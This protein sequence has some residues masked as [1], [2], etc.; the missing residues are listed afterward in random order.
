[1]T[2]IFPIGRICTL[3]APVWRTRRISRSIP[4]I[5]L[6]SFV[7]QTIGCIAVSKMKVECQSIRKELFAFKGQFAHKARRTIERLADIG[8]DS[9]HLL[10]CARVECFYFQLIEPP[11]R[12]FKRTAEYHLAIS[13]MVA[14]HT[15]TAQIVQSHP[16]IIIRIGEHSAKPKL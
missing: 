6:H 3:F 13:I 11:F 14:F 9:L 5:F 12:G 2:F 4:I 8:V 16:I 15:P 10:P 1:M 7:R